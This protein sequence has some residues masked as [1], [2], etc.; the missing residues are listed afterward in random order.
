MKRLR[1]YDDDLDSVGGGGGEK[2]G[3][4]WGGG[5]GGRRREKK[6]LDR[7]LSSSH[8]RFYDRKGLSS[9]SSYDRSL[10]DDREVSKSSRKQRI[11]QDSSEPFDRTT[12]RKNNFDRYRENSDRGIPVSPRNVYGSGGG[13][14]SQLH[15]SDSVSG[16][17]RDYPKGIRSERDR[18]RREGSVSSRRE[19]TSVF[20]WRRSNVLN[21]DSGEDPKLSSDLSRGGPTNN[22]RV[23]S[24]D[25]V[26]V[27]SPKGSWRDVVKSPCRSSKDVVV[28]SPQGLDDVVVKSP[29][30]SSVK[31]SQGWSRDTVK[32][33]QGWSR[34]AI[35]SPQG[36]SR[37]VVAS[38]QGASRDAIKSPQG[39]SR[40]VKSPPWSKES[41]CEQSKSGEVKKNDEVQ[42]ESG[43]SSEMEEGELEP[44]P[45][46]VPIEKS[47][48]IAENPVVDMREA[49]YKN[50]IVP[51]VEESK[52]LFE[53]KLEGNGDIGV[54]GKQETRGLVTLPDA[55][56]ENGKLPYS[57]DS[58]VGGISGSKEEDEEKAVE[59]EENA[60]SKNEC[61]STTNVKPRPPAEEVESEGESAMK[62]LPFEE[63]QEDGKGI[64]PEVKA[65]DVD[66]VD[67]TK[68]AVEQDR[69]PDVALTLTNDK[70][71]QNIKDKGKSLAVSPSSEANSNENGRWMERDLLLPRDDAMEGPSSRGF[72][73]FFSPIVTRIEKINSSGINNQK[74]EK[75]KIEPLELCLGLPNV[76]LPLPLA[77]VDPIP[78]PSSPSQARS[79]QSF[80]T[81]L[82]SNSDAFT[83]SMSFSGSQTFV[84]N[85]SCSLTQ[86]SFENNYEQSVGSHPIFQGI[87][88]ASVD[89]KR[90]EVP[91][92]QRILLNGN[93]SLQAPQTSQG[94]LNSQALQGQHHKVFEGSIN[95]VPVRLDRQSSLSRQLSG[96]QSRHHDDVRSPSNSMGSQD[97][98]SEYSNK[99]RL[100][101]ERSSGS[102]IRSN[103]QREFE[104]Q[105]VMGG[106]G[107]GEKI[108]A[109]IVSEPIQVMASRFQEMTEQSIAYLKKITFEMIMHEIK[110]E[111][112]QKALQKR[113]D[114]TLEALLK[115]H[116]VQLEILVALKTGVRDFLQRSNNIPSS[117]LADIFLNL[118]CRNPACR[119]LIPVDECDCKVCLQKIGFC[120]SC[121]C[122][123]CSKFDMASNTCSWVGCDV[124]LHWCHTDCGLRESFIRNGQSVTGA[125]GATEMQ[126][127]CVACDHPSEMFGFVKEVFKTCAKEWKAETFSKE[128]EYVKRI[129]AASNDWRGRKLHDIA[130]HMLPRLESKSNVS[131]VYNFIMGFFTSHSIKPGEGSSIGGVAPVQEAKWLAASAGTG[132][133]TPRVE[134]ASKAPPL[135]DWDHVVGSKHVGDPQ[136][137]LLT[138]T[139]KK[140]VVDDLDSIVRIKKAEAKMFQERADDAKREAEG[141]KRIAIAKSEKIEEEYRSRITKLRLVEAEERRK[142]KLEE[143]Q[144]MER[145]HREYLS[146]KTRM[147]ADIKDLLIKMES[148][149]GNL[150]S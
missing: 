141:L 45:N 111:Q 76:S 44:E 82:R 88:Q 42:R 26:N 5:G 10:D 109:M 27:K 106:T 65:E 53:E 71:T 37:E 124:C 143:L 119:S 33:P 55:V 112:L 15:R 118:K 11:D 114:V 39:S 2:G 1:S 34:D 6:D 104:Q 87:D 17:R 90:K 91:L 125:H 77:S 129:F 59:L 134:S 86:N 73:L 80:P 3:G 79:I 68:E 50:K 14:R 40:D 70:L 64:D 51:D 24:E 137:E 103:S 29:Q 48:L 110:C 142:Q 113:S 126:F 74:D 116:R 136:K 62:S 101:R 25:R 18:S 75:L 128:L 35:K 36:S 12:G 28:K 85:P 67:S 66:L 9:S 46:S 98:R 41:S 63:L 135:L 92:Y 58:S 38:P 138:N 54:D 78:T 127:H 57:E 105:L 131:E 144:V 102:L 43:N 150:G 147:E 20:S 95:G 16:Y 72:E 133:V 97:T 52:Y 30:G 8:R 23:T 96:L 115:S 145:E 84:H 56:K 4:S 93:G 21:K 89:L 140:Y 32:S 49:E 22:Q 81:T 121:M 31:S 7:S 146:M 123:V 99:K 108:I 130:S 122:L 60:R 117:D 139:D 94:I 107:F 132:K 149:T 69:A 61:A 100:M 148:T 47:Q 120:S 83:T 19:E 13:D